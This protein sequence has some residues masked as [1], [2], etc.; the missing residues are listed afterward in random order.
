MEDG[1]CALTPVKYEYPLCLTEDNTL[2]I[3]DTILY[4]WQPFSDLHKRLC[5][6][7]ASADIGEKHVGSFILQGWSKGVLAIRKGKLIKHYFHL[8]YFGVRN[9]ITE[10]NEVLP[11]FRSF[12]ELAIDHNCF[13]YNHNQHKNVTICVK[14][15]IN[16]HP[17]VLQ[18]L[19]LFGFQRLMREDD[20]VYFIKYAES[21]SKNKIVQ[22]EIK[23]RFTPQ[24]FTKM[25]VDFDQVNPKEAL[26]ILGSSHQFQWTA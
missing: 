16:T 23:K 22:L 25:K 21:I 24:K 13:F 3:Q 8:G 19:E 20:D 2:N 10:L 12:T 4:N 15:Y 6:W 14:V 11:A 17:L 5:Q 26:R 9:N 18:C 7:S 1:I